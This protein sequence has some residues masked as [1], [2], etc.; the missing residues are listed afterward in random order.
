MSKNCSGKRNIRVFVSVI[1]GHLDVLVSICEISHFLPLHRCRGW[2][3]YKAYGH[4][5][6]SCLRDRIVSANALATSWTWIHVSIV[7]KPF[8]F[9]AGN[10]YRS[11]SYSFHRL[12]LSDTKIVIVVVLVFRQKVVTVFCNPRHSAQ[13]MFPLI[14]FNYIIMEGFE[15]D[16]RSSIETS[17]VLLINW[18]EF[19]LWFDRT[20]F[21]SEVS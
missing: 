2:N 17:Y 9:V 12:L 5:L 21:D 7:K 13:K 18:T 3:G 19:L 8:C 15:E 11:L 4:I 6:S 20:S 16:P 10:T 14:I 1:W